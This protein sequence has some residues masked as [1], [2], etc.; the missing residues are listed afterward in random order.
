TRLIPHFWPTSYAV[1]G[2]LVIFVGAIIALWFHTV[3][4]TRDYHPLPTLED[5]ESPDSEYFS[6][7]RSCH[8]FAKY[9]AHWKLFRPKRRS[10]NKTK[11]QQYSRQLVVRWLKSQ[12]LL[13]DGG[14]RPSIDDLGR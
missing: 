10:A 4:N 13:L 7:R 14:D 12:D 2:F 5:A 8:R 9:L 1:V 6:H 3:Y 11:W